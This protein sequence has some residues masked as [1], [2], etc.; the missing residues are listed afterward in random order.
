MNKKLLLL[1]TFLCSSF[2]TLLQASTPTASR[3]YSSRFVREIP[4]SQQVGATGTLDNSWGAFG[5]LDVTGGILNGIPQKIV[6]LANGSTLN[7][8]ADSSN[9]SI[10]KQYTATGSLDVSFAG[11]GIFSRSGYQAPVNS[12]MI[13]SHNRIMICGNSDPDGYVWITRLTPTGS[14]D[15]TFN[16][17]DHAVWFSLNCC[18]QQSSGN[19]I[20]SGVNIA[21]T[22]IQVARY[23]ERGVLDTT[24]GNEGYIVFD[25][26]GVP[27]LPN[28]GSV[29]SSIVVGADDSIFVAYQGNIAKF[30]SAGAVDTAFNT[31][32]IVTGGFGQFAAFNTNGNICIAGTNDDFDIQINCYNANSGS[33]T[34]G[35][36]FSTAIISEGSNHLEVYNFLTTTDGGYLIFSSD[37]TTQSI[38][39]D[40]I[41]ASG[42]ANSIF[43]ASAQ[44]P[45]SIEFL[46][47]TG[48][49]F[50]TGGGCVDP[51]GRLY[52]LGYQYDGEVTTSINISRLFNY[53]GITQI[54][55]YPA[56]QAQG[57]VNSFFGSGNTSVGDGVVRSFDGVFGVNLVQK[58]GP[59]LELGVG[60]YAHTI[61]VGSSGKLDTSNNANMILTNLS[62]DGSLNTGFATTGQQNLAKTYTDEYLSSM[63]EDKDGNLIVGGYNGGNTAFVRKY[64]SGGSTGAEL[65]AAVQI[66][67]APT[68]INLVGLQGNQ[69]ILAFGQLDATHGFINGYTPGGILDSTQFNTDGVVPG[70]ISGADFPGTPLQ[71]MGAIYTACVDTLDNIYIAYQNTDTGG[72]DIAAIFGD[73]SGLISQF[74]VHGTTPGTINDVFGET[75]TDSSY[76][77]LAIDNDGD[78]IVAAGINGTYQLK[79]IFVA[80]AAIDG[81]FDLAFGTDGLLTIE[82]GEVNTLIN[83]LTT[84][85]NNKIIITGASDSSDD[86]AMLVIRVTQDGAL[87]T[88][89]NYAGATPGILSLQVGHVIPDYYLR[90]LTGL[91]VQAATGNMVATG[92]EQQVAS[93]SVPMT[94]NIYGQPGTTQV[95]QFPIET[96]G[97]PGTL[98][99]HFSLTDLP[100][101]GSINV[102][103]ISGAS[104]L[105]G[106]TKAIYMYLSG[107]PKQGY[108]LIGVD[109]GTDTK[110]A[111]IRQNDETLDPSFGTSGITTLTG[112]T[113]INHISIDADN[114]ILI[115]G[116]Q[117]GAGWA[118]RLSADGVFD[119]LFAPQTTTSAALVSAIGV[120]Q[121]ESGRY[122]VY[123]TNDSGNG[124]IVAYQDLLVG[125]ETNLQVDTTFNPLGTYPGQ[126]TV[127]S[128]GLFNLTIN[129][130]DT[131]LVAYLASTIVN[132]AKITANGSQ[133]VTSFGASGVLNTGI[134]ASNPSA[135]RCAIDSNGKVIVAASFGGTTVKVCRYTAAGATDSS[136]NGTGAVYTLPS[137]KLGTSGVILTDLMITNQPNPATN[138]KIILLGYNSAGGNGR[139]FASRLGQDGVLDPT[140]NASPSGSDIPGIT[141]FAV[142]GGAGANA[143]ALYSGSIFING[144]IYG[145]VATNFDATVSNALLVCIFGDDYIGQAAEQPLA[146]AAGIID[147]TLDTAGNTGALNL[148]LNGTYGAFSTLSLNG[149]IAQALHIYA[150]GSMLMGFSNNTWTKVVKLNAATNLDTTFG[151]GTGYVLAPVANLR[152]IFVAD[153]TNDDGSIYC[154]GYDADNYI[155]TIKISASGLL[156]NFGVL[157]TSGTYNGYYIAPN[158]GTI[159]NG[160]TVRQ[161]TNSRVLVACYGFTGGIIIAYTNDGSGFDY[162][163]ANGNAAISI[164][165]SYA[166]PN[167]Q[168]DVE[169]RIYASYLDGAF[170]S[171]VRILENGSAVDT[172]FTATPISQTYALSFSQ[173]K[174]AIDNTNNQFV[175]AVQDGTATGNILK[176]A[177]YSLVDGSSTGAVNTISIA[178]KVLNLSDLFIDDLQNIYVVGY[179]ATD[180][181]GIVAKVKST[182]ATTLALDTTYAADNSSPNIP[183]VANVN[184][185]VSGYIVG[186]GGFH[187]DRRVYLLGEQPAAQ[188]TLSR[189]FG[190]VYTVQQD[191]AIM[192]AL[193]GTIDT[194]LGVVGVTPGDGGITLSTLSDW[195]ILSGYAAKKVVANANGTAS[196]IFSNGSNWILGQ[197]NADVLPFSSF[198]GEV[199]GL[200]NPTSGV[201]SANAIT[202]DSQNRILV[203]GMNTGSTAQVVQRYASDADPDSTET[204]AST[205]TMASVSRI[206][207][208]TSSRILLAGSALF[209]S[210]FGFG[211]IM[212]YQNTGEAI[213]PTYGPYGSNGFYTT[214]SSSPIDDMVLDQ[215]DNAYIVYRGTS[216]TL[217]K[218]TANGSG[219][220]P[221][222]NDGSPL[223]TGII[224]TDIVHIGI[225]SESNIL[226]AVSNLNASITTALYNGT[227]GALI[228]SIHDLSSLNDN[229][230]FVTEITAANE[231]FLIS[232]YEADSPYQMLTIRITSEG[233]LDTTF[234]SPTG[235]A[236]YAPQSASSVN[237][238]AV[239]PNGQILMVGVSNAVNPII[240]RLYGAAYVDQVQQAPDAYPAGTLDLTL[241]P[242]TGAF[243]FATTYPT[244]N[245]E[246]YTARRMYTYS[247]NNAMLFV[248][249]NESNTILMRLN[250]DF[251]LD[252]TFGE[253]EFE[254]GYVLIPDV[255]NVRGLCVDSNNN[256]FISGGDYPSWVRAFDST[257]VVLSGFDIPSATMSVMGTEIVQQSLDRIVL[258]GAD[259]DGGALYAYT[260]TG[261]LDPEFGNNGSGKYSTGVIM[262]I[263][264]VAV[265]NYD[266]IVITYT[267]GAGNS[268]M[269]RINTSS[270]IVEFTSDVP[271]T[272]V[273]NNNLRV[274]ENYNNNI[275]YVA[276]ATTTGFSIAAYSSAN[277]SL[278]VGP[279]NITSAGS[280]TCY[281]ANIFATSNNKL[282]LVGYNSN[283]NLIVAARLNGD[284]SLD[285]S[286]NP[287]GTPQGVLQTTVGA[288][289]TAFDT[290][291]FADNRIMIVGGNTSQTAPYMCRVYGDEYV[292]LVPQNPTLGIAGHCDYTLDIPNYYFNLNALGAGALNN[293]SANVIL[294]LPNG[295]Q[296]VVFDN[297]TVS[298][299][300]RLTEGSNSAPALDTT[301]QTDGI[302]DATALSGASSIFIDSLGNIVLTGSAAGAGWIQRYTSTGVLDTS[303][304]GTGYIRGLSGLATVALEQSMA[305]LI[306]AGSAAGIGVVRGYQPNGTV[307]T[308]FGTNGVFSVG[309]AADI[310]S[311]VADEFD[312]II[313]A[314]KRGANI[315]V[316]RL[317]SNGELDITFGPSNNG[318]IPLALTNVNSD[319]S[320][321][322]LALDESGRIIVVA[323]NGTNS[324]P[325]N[326]GMLVAAYDNGT[327]AS[328]NGANIY[329]ENYLLSGLTVGS[330][331]TSL[332]AT[333]DTNMLLSIYEQGTGTMFIVRLTNAGVL[334][335]GFNG[336]GFNEYTING[337]AT[338]RQLNDIAVLPDGRILNV[339]YEVVSGIKYPFITRFY[340]NPYQDELTQCLDAL[341][342]GTNDITFGLQNQNILTFFAGSTNPSAADLQKARAVGIQNNNRFVVALDGQDTPSSTASQLYINRF[343]MDGILDTTFNETGQAALP[344]YY[345]SE[346]VNDMLVYQTSTGVNK[347]ILAGY[348]YN[349]A[350]DVNNSLLISYNLDTASYDTTFGGFDGDPAGQ[351]FADVAQHNIVGQQSSGRFIVGGSN[352][353]NIGTILGYTSNG[354]LDPSFGSDGFYFAYS[355]AIGHFTS[356]AI[357]THAIDNQDRIVFAYNY[358]DTIFMTRLLADGSGLD[359]DFNSGD[360]IWTSLNPISNPSH[361]RVAIDANNKIVIAGLSDTGQA[362]LLQR[363]NPDGS[364]D[365][366]VKRISVSGNY[367]ISLSQATLN[368]LLIDA[369]N[370]IIV[371]A[372]NNV[373]EFSQI[374]I[375][376]IQSNMSG[377]DTTF[378]GT[379]YLQYTNETMQ[380]PLDGMIHP[381]GRIVV[382][383]S[384]EELP[385]A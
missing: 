236:A 326:Q 254:S 250:K 314:Y 233:V 9:L 363:Y 152:D 305:R 169:N 296:Y 216:V 270:S 293:S 281:L 65:W 283:G 49:S 21:N 360:P 325:N 323:M 170:I 78:L 48:G 370:K 328:G 385:L 145:A 190:D 365:V 260:T 376:R 148:T 70:Q 12:I 37:T 375:V 374:L 177:R 175:V 369:D 362:I 251:T 256:I 239:Q 109:T 322:R 191:E 324:S 45:G 352:Y 285:S 186:A 88:T 72:V 153:G 219:L 75:I 367:P 113:G 143:V 196:I 217:E 301:F 286:F 33:P 228:G 127:G 368:K 134:T 17:I 334:D 124:V 111:R 114:K 358:G 174:T 71:Y 265:D 292:S 247:S 357:F 162:T 63:I 158:N 205:I 55:T 337:S 312:R 354:K 302:A 107:S 155:Q 159:F 351:A 379:G 40:S 172:S 1:A 180:N 28:V 126:Y 206:A 218:V 380:S 307:D 166:Q 237:G 343:N 118:L 226:V 290:T 384:Q 43:N 183:G 4:D 7:L 119:V 194:T 179:N 94:M 90:N 192:K 167:L 13:D 87:D 59:V 85:N 131:I 123:G 163:F 211:T 142:N 95:R 26:S 373:S 244:V 6:A 92:Y 327:A 25:G 377:L 50:P 54:P 137:D 280:G 279:V 74:N 104:S 209:D 298:K 306:V 42:L 91:V 297:G 382:C 125:A 44:I 154:T 32:G 141:T 350:L 272:N 338:S 23:T 257:G 275:I 243:D 372:S 356:N 149:Y 208:Q 349:T 294:T 335:S 189:L 223:E 333:E 227:T 156:E 14:V 284:L 8:F 291:I 299:L 64:S 336:S 263:A 182:S 178:G 139:L 151:G 89:F 53:P 47:N 18:S 259:E 101:D 165:S 204:F 93:L 38:R 321:V 197:I 235:I 266:R 147:T 222:F 269:Q 76:V 242:P 2:V 171:T 207:E 308:L 310:Y 340:N 98:D 234:A 157:Q 112:V 225:N 144:Q 52:V 300:V 276:A 16:F 246:D 83:Q 161:S 255:T 66:G 184:T 249:D 346:Y 267:D 77:R 289:T 203:A 81:T 29:P 10:L 200:A 282:Q 248:F 69:R 198:G 3:I 57:D 273:I 304:N 39:V 122:L 316:A 117:G 201:S 168:L 215:Y 258:A 271:L 341:P 46:S 86:D 303:F 58:N 320:S 30:T 62:V 309:T 146:V 241:N 185:N 359:P 193:Q 345:D 295:K 199:G 164:G 313:I 56:E 383:G 5:N 210:E 319:Q 34:T 140:W 102:A 187:P 240:M 61:L 277:G 27:A 274:L 116:T 108:Y 97:N 315:E 366:S 31:T 364:V 68:Q 41:T 347:A 220:D 262:P 238:L 348:A 245:L 231:N 261:S 232:A 288:M 106:A 181:Y 195:S 311:M 264:D 73:G 330:K 128:T 82:I 230:P 99:T 160:S 213:D 60:D 22:H 332:V 317:T 229:S 121:Q 80:E 150:D 221:I 15:S 331:I 287:D 11:T 115:A 135:I 133:L 176:V 329:G 130:D 100:T 173:I 318:V 24:F 342:I 51:I 214:T 188:P 110:I 339:G 35:T 268:V 84:L 381:D 67:S 253:G 129:N 355:L 224:P 361:V 212:A 136:F 202:V 138:D 344:Q 105:T 371:V 19:I 120:A 36:I 353:N 132:I 20:V 79:K 278:A 378:N 96:T 103:D 252:T